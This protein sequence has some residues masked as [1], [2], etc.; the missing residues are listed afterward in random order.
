MSASTKARAAGAALGCM[1]AALGALVLAS[2]SAGAQASPG[3]RPSAQTVLPPPPRARCLKVLHLP[4]Y[5]PPQLQRAY[6]L[7]PLYRRGLNGGGA[8]S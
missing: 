2:G 5:T 3:A 7:R 8:R 6:D 4:C 1:L